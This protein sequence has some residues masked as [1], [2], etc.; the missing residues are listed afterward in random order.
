[1]KV[2]GSLQGPLRGNTHTACA[3]CVIQP[4]AGFIQPRFRCWVVVLSD[5]CVVGVGKSKWQEMAGV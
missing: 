2:S 1:M 5:K 4:A 3:F